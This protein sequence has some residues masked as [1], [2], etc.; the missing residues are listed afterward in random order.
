MDR[1]QFFF[2]QRFVT[3][4]LFALFYITA[5]ILAIVYWRRCSSACALVLTGSLLNLL[6]MVGRFVLPLALG[7]ADPALFNVGFFVLNVLSLGGHGL[8][9]GAVF[10]GRRDAYD[11]A[12]RPRRPRADDGEDWDRPA[13]KPPPADSTGIQE[14]AR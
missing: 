8:I 14:R 10:A 3:P 4:A 13:P 5:L 2:L 1:D 6:I 7:G 11:E 9:L 12:A